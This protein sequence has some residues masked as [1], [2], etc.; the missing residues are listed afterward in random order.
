[1]REETLAEKVLRIEA[2][3][4]EQGNQETDYDSLGDPTS[5]SPPIP[6]QPE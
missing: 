5:W 3:I 2:W 4:R 6:P 1:M